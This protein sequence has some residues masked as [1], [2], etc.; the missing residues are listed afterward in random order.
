MS[1]T[2]S[3]LGGA[4][5]ATKNSQIA[6]AL[7]G[8]HGVHQPRG[9]QAI[10][11]VHYDDTVALAPLDG[12][13]GSFGGQVRFALPK[14][15]TL[16]GP[17]HLEIVINKGLTTNPWTNQPAQ[18][19]AR[20]AFMKNAGDLMLDNVALRYGNNILQQYTGEFQAIWRRLCYHDVNIEATNVNVLGALP[21]GNPTEDVLEDALTLR[22]ATVGAG[23]T[24]AAPAAA[25]T[26]LYVPL[27]ELYFVHNRDEYWMPESL[28]LE[29]ELIITFP[30]LENICYTSSGD[31]TVFSGNVVLSVGPATAYAPTINSTRL[32]YQEITLSAAEKENRLQL[33]KSPEGHVIK[34]L[35]L[36]RQPPTY[37][38]SP[39]S[40]GQNVQVVVQL[41]SFRMDG[42]EIV[43]CVRKDTDPAGGVSVGWAGS[44]LETNTTNSIITGAPVNTIVPITDFR[45]TAAGKEIYVTQPE[46]WNRTVIR[47][48]YHPDSQIADN[49]YIIPFALFPEDRK[50]ATGHQSYSVLGTLRIVINFPDVAFVG[51]YRVDCWSHS[52]NLIQSRKGGITKAQH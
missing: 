48:R 9:W 38:A 1:S 47:K 41:D 32:R 14:N 22:A 34:F 46:D 7:L 23:P 39:N 42:A 28:A 19:Q 31:G 6:Q 51:Q 5:V 21:P 49:Y 20:A 43:F 10:T 24:Y 25:T 44:N 30:L 50:N 17:C 40:A 16:I 12:R 3:G 13:S 27:E 18:P 29:G 4:L 52:H 11:P 37:I 36:E 35:D 26:T 33:F 15:S 2:L 45:V 8:T